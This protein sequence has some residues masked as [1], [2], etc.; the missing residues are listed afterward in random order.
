MPQERAP[1]PGWPRLAPP[2]PEEPCGKCSSPTIWTRFVSGGF[3]PRLLPWGSLISRRGSDVDARM[4]T[5]CGYIEL[6]AREPAKL[7]DRGRS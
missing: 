2:E 4:C 5:R 3:A 1:A 7:V 6:F